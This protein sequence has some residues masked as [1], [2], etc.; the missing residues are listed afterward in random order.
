MAEIKIT[1]DELKNFI[2]QNK[3]LMEKMDSKMRLSVVNNEI[4]IGKLPIH[5]NKWTIHLLRSWLLNLLIKWVG[6]KGVT[7]RNI[8]ISGNIIFVDLGCGRTSELEIAT[9]KEK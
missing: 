9:G 3:A 2:V 4:R 1:L 8:T 6:L 5:I 7:V